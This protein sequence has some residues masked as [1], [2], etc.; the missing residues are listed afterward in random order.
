MEEVGKLVNTYLEYLEIEKN[1]SKLTIRNYK[2]YLSRFLDW[3]AS[4]HPQTVL[5][6]INIDLVRKYRIYLS[7]Y[8]DDKGMTLMRITQSYHIIAL[9]SFLRFVYYYE[10]ARSYGYFPLV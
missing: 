3:L 5:K 1:A 8:A 10:S 4:N 7:D 9:R 6:T 2:F